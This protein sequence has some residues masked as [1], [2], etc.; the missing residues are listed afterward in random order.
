MNRLARVPENIKGIHVTVRV[1]PK[2]DKNSTFSIIDRESMRMNGDERSLHGC[3][4][5]CVRANW[6]DR[7]PGPKHGEG[8]IVRVGQFMDHARQ[9][10]NDHGRPSISCAT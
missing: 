4:H 8:R 1:D 2:V 5:T 7:H 6:R 10:R 9:W 3:A